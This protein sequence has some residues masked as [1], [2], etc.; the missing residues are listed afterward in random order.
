MTGP[1]LHHHKNFTFCAVTLQFKNVKNILSSSV[2]FIEMKYFRNCHL[3]A[4]L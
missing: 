2:S 4:P 3:I 1:D